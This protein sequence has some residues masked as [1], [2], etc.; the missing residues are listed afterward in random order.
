M[1]PVHRSD[2]SSGSSIRTS[3][4]PS[5]MRYS[6]AGEP[7][8]DSRRSR[9]FPND[10]VLTLAFHF[11]ARINKL[12]Q[13]GLL[14]IQQNP[15]TRLGGL[16]IGTGNMYSKQSRQEPNAMDPLS[17]NTL[18]DRKP[19][20]QQDYGVATGTRPPSALES[21]FLRGMFL[22]CASNAVNAKQRLVENA[23]VTPAAG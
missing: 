2:P 7:L 13:T 6:F 21:V 5:S 10:M 23:A 22:H 18:T 1:L 17:T 16:C 14:A 11:P 15:D 3:T 20:A 12:H 19:S 8:T 9:M 4:F